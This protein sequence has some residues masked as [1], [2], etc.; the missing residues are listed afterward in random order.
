MS[1]HQTCE[2]CEEHYHCDARSRTLCMLPVCFSL[3]RRRHNGGDD[4]GPCVV[5]AERPAPRVGQLRYIRT[6]T[7][8]S[9]RLFTDIPAIKIL[10]KLA[11]A[12]LLLGMAYYAFYAVLQIL[13]IPYIFYRF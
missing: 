5:Q 13:Q 4:Y 11:V 10:L 1:G 7:L 3:A 8:V 2:R 6:P 12:T 9:F